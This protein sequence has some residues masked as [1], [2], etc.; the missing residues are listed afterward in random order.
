MAPTKD[1]ESLIS[2][3]RYL[4]II[5]GFWTDPIGTHYITQKTFKLYS[6]FMRSS[7]FVW[8]V[9]LV[10]EF[11][12]LVILHYDIAIITQSFGV[13]VNASKLMMK[14]VIYWRNKT[15]QMI[16]DIAANEQKVWASGDD[17]IFS[18]YRRHIGLLKYYIVAMVFA[19]FMVVFL[20]Q[21]VGAIQYLEI[22]NHNILF[23][24]TVESH[25]MYLTLIPRN[26][27]DH[28]VFLLTSQF[29]WGFLGLTFNS[30]THLLFA[31]LLVYCR[32]QLITLQIKSRKLFGGDEDK[33]L[34]ELDDKGQV[35]ALKQLIRDHQYIIRFVE[36]LNNRV[37]YIIMMEFILSSLDFASVLVTIVGTDAKTFCWLAIFM[38]L[39]GI[40]LYLLSWNSNEV[41]IQSEAIGDALFESQW[42]LLS[43]EGKQMI[44]LMIF[45]SQ[46][47]LQMTI[48][49]FGPM[50]TSSVV[51]ILKTAYSYA[52]LLQSAE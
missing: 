48:G 40:Q 31:T 4:L 27:Q 28:P 23:N 8:W 39:L 35:Q 5:A 11:A 34:L 15:L 18:L 51:W 6:L 10:G 20:L 16:K 43:K 45:R 52:T 14:V 25:S 17:E 12:R 21:G 29:L 44:Q 30:I 19:T 50:T 3:M 24:E 9:L 41:K 7:C 2:W 36:D 49:P 33:A 37:K 32:I 22:R 26:K 46:K 47:P 1:N 42:Y 38:V 13:V